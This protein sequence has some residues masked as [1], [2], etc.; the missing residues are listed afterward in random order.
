MSSR[1]VQNLNG[2]WDYRVGEGAWS[3]IS[4][5]Y[6][7]LPVGFST[8]RKEF[9]LQHKRSCSFLVFEGITYS[10]IVTFNDVFLGEMLP[11][12]EY[13]FDISEYVREKGNQLNVV[14]KDI[15]VTFGPSEGWENYGGIIR[16]VYIEYTN[17]YTIDDVF[18]YTDISDDFS[19][20]ECNVKVSH[21]GD[22]SAVILYE[23]IDENGTLCAA[24]ESGT[25]I[26]FFLKN[27]RLWSPDSPILY[28][29]I[30][31]LKVGN[32]I[33]DSVTKRV[34]FKKF[35][36]KGKRFYL[37]GN[38]LFLIGVC[39]HDIWGDNGHTLT[40]EQMRSDMELIKAQGVNYVRLVHYPHHKYIIE[41]ADELGLLISEE[42]GLWWSDMHNQKLCDDSL[43]VLEKTVIRD[44]SHISVAFW[45][46]FNECI[47]TPEF[48]KDSAEVCRLADPTHMVSGANCMSIEMTKKYFIENGFD[49][50]TMHP[51]CD[52]PKYLWDSVTA[53][54]DKPVLFTEWGGY[55]VWENND[56][57]SRF[58]DEMVKMWRNSED[59]PVLAGASL[60]AWS[61]M[62]EFSRMEPACHDGVLNEGLTDIYRKPHSHFALFKEKFAEINQKPVLEYGFTVNSL[63]I[64]GN[65]EAIEI[66]TRQTEESVLEIAQKLCAEPIAKFYY[67]VKK[68]RHIKLGPIL[69]DA[70]Q[71]V[72]E[73][74]VNFCKCPAI[75]SEGSVTF[76]IG[77]T[78]KTLFVFGNVSLPYGFPTYGEYGETV[79]EYIIDYTDGGVHKVPLRN[80]Y[81]ITT[82]LT[83]YGPSRIVPVAANT[84]KVIDFHYDKDSEVY[85]FSVLKI[86]V[87]NKEIKSITLR[88]DNKNY[89]VLIYGMTAEI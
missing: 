57:F 80:G 76:D 24:S 79:G 38:P 68:T 66:D 21:N 29:L 44:R 46:S 20:A 82:A 61:D 55:M 32:E 37:N 84:E 6:S 54:T 1:I 5:P 36:V 73:M 77:K 81:E 53:L 50:Y 39:R 88:V 60:W 31:K 8:C 85:T 15:D 3:K 69:K 59:M 78:A 26:K 7:S 86:P 17:K 64:I 12:S 74:P 27:I 75:V 34:G 33:F 13:R 43:K 4:V 25:D 22:D 16:D 19:S 67:D 28:T 72:G 14:I 51:Y 23:L 65:F 56:L 30:L 35:E 52:N 62:Y 83:I 9:D 41:L 42:P 2:E 40:K 58:V 87:E 45:L 48:I 89:A 63:E 71:S 10:A 18:W 11:Y 47:F 70:P 49:F